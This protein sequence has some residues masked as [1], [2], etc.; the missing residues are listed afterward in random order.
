MVINRLAH[1]VKTNRINASIDEQKGM[2]T[3]HSRGNISNISDDDVLSMLRDNI[4]GTIDLTNRFHSLRKSIITSSIYVKKSLTT[5]QGRGQGMSS[6]SVTVGY[7][8]SYF[9]VMDDDEVM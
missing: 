7:D 9:D 5:S 3:F 4:T 1:L 2:V 6:S 8:D